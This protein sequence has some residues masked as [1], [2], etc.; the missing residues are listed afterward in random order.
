MSKFK[1]DNQK[2][3]TEINGHYSF[4]ATDAMD[5]NDP[6]IAAHHPQT[7]QRYR[8]KGINLSA[9]QLRIL[10]DSGMLNYPTE[11]EKTKIGISEENGV[12]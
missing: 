7:I 5:L 8:R 3:G 9:Y 12:L 1:D 4:I 6:W 10:K 11:A 2:R